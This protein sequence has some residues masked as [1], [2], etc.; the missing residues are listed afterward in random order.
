MRK[1][2]LVFF[3]LTFQFSFCQDYW[4]IKSSS[5]HENK[6]DIAKDIK[7]ISLK[8][9]SFTKKILSIKNNEFL[10]IGASKLNAR[11]IADNARDKRFKHITGDTI[12]G[13]WTDS[14]EY[15]HMM[16]WL[17]W[18]HWYEILTE[19]IKKS[20]TFE[21]K[22]SQF[23]FGGKYKDLQAL[24]KDL[25][26]AN[27]DKPAKQCSAAEGLAWFITFNGMRN[28]GSHPSKNYDLTSKEEEDYFEK[29][30]DKIKV[31]MQNILNF[32]TVC[33]VVI[34]MLILKLITIISKTI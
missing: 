15:P 32:L 31:K 16:M 24:I 14:N 2:I 4:K 25:Y 27:N 1:L 20:K 22:Y 8:N 30:D 7:Y 5:K 18:D 34:T 10:K 13:K 33:Q 29:L 23:Q 17:Q 28:P 26:F 12:K 6:I 11:K 21:S 9:K 3:A 19:I